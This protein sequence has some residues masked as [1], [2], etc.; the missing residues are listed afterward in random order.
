MAT[1]LYY[2][3]ERDS[4]IKIED[5]RKAGLGYAF[6]TACSPIGVARGPGD[7]PGAGPAGVVVADTS[8]LGDCPH[9]YLCFTCA[10]DKVCKPKEP[11]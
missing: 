2:L 3:P 5:V 9:G 1:F 7:K 8:R 6:E 4:G 10:T 11:Q